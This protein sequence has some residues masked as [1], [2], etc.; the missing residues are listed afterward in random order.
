MRM[1]LIANLAIEFITIGLTVVLLVLPARRTELALWRR[2][3]L[4]GLRKRLTRRLRLDEPLR[5][6]RTG[7]IARRNLRWHI[8]LTVVMLTQT[9]AGLVS[10][11]LLRQAVGAVLALPVLAWFAG[12]LVQRH[13]LAILAT[14]KGRR[15]F[16]QSG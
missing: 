1:A 13:K 5:S 6:D 14:R 16:A 11:N 4:P 9:F 7:Q 8:A 2:W 10:E 12:S 15:G 3:R